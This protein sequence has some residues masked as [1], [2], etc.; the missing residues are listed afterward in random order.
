MVET[1]SRGLLVVLS[2]PSGAGKR[3]LRQAWLREQPNTLFS[4][5]VTTR[6]PRQGE[7]PGEDYIFVEKEDF[8]RLVRNEELVEWATVFG[9]SY[10][11]PGAPIEAALT[12]GRD[13]L[14]EKDVQGAAQLRETH[15][16][17]VFVFV[18]PPSF[19]ELQRRLVSRGTEKADDVATRLARYEEE[20]SHIRYYDY[21]IVND[22]LNR[23][24]AKLK[25]IVEAERCRAD[26]FLLKSG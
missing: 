17:G 19:E 20:L 25:A 18:L 9:H 5:S 22:C 24:V 26:R 1:T 8:E 6:P 13:V 23:A 4:P 16:Y 7:I 14:V 15:G 2:A 11:T 12:Q 3:T 21:V 10:G